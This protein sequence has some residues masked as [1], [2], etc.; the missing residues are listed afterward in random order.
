MVSVVD[1]QQPYAGFRQISRRDLLKYAA[2]LTP[3]APSASTWGKD[4]QR[5][6]AFTFD[7]PKTDEGAGLSWKGINQRML[8]A[9]AKHGIRTVLFVTGKRVDSEAGRNLVA[10]WDLAGHT[11]GNHS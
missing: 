2:I 10:A 3:F 5:K 1:D 7:D 11:I 8:A 4:K 9:L 6:I